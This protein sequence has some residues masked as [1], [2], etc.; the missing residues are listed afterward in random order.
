MELGMRLR[1]NSTRVLFGVYSGPFR[2]PT[3]RP[4]S[5]PHLRFGYLAIFCHGRRHPCRR[6]P[7]VPVVSGAPTSVRG[8]PVRRRMGARAGKGR[9]GVLLKY[10]GRPRVVRRRAHAST[11]A[12]GNT[13]GR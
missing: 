5:P 1:G 2:R 3:G 10:C 11:V 13:H 4:L 7:T 12:N 8:K 6:R 9:S